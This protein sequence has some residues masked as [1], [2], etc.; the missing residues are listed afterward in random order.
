MRKDVD[1][2]AVQIT[3]LTRAVEVLVDKVNKLNPPQ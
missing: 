2:L 1:E 3:G